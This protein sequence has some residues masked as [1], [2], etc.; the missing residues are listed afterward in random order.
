ML[1]QYSIKGLKIEVG[2]SL[3]NSDKSPK[4]YYYRNYGGLLIW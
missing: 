2:H 3:L 1:L 4:I